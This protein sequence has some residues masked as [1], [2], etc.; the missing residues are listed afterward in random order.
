MIQARA[1]D[2]HPMPDF[3]LAIDV[4]IP[5]QR[6]HDVEDDLEAS[7]ASAAR[8]TIGQAGANSGLEIRTAAEISIVLGNDAL[9]QGLNRDFR[10]Q[11]R[12]TN[13]LSFPF[14][15]GEAAAC[16]A[17]SGGPI[18]LGDVVLA[19]DTVTREADEQA[20]SPR[21]HTLHLV[22]HGVLHLMG[23]D[24]GTEAE[25]RVMERMEQQVLANLG[26]A[27]PYLERPPLA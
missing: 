5:E 14:A 22:V 9:V 23:Y 25:A 1:T 4:A 15:D 20:K 17:D 19:F 18:M 2:G 16:A 24:H 21:D 12:P 26:I 7:V 11:D 8:A 27:D 10:D 6:W 13:V 3:D